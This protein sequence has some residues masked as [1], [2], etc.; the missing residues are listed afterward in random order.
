[1]GKMML[2]EGWH[3]HSLDEATIWL[4]IVEDAKVNQKGIQPVS[5]I[6][7]KKTRTEKT[8]L[9]LWDHKHRKERGRL[10][11][12]GVSLTM[13]ETDYFQADSPHWS[14]ESLMG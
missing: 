14:I 12:Q 13:Q 9:R 4:K 10:A 7:C 3:L 2:N 6:Y 1:M 5:W 11:V 8:L